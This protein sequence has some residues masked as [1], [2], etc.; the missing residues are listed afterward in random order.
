MKNLIYV[1]VATVLLTALSSCGG[2]ESNGPIPSVSL[3]MESD[4][5]WKQEVISVIDVREAENIG[6]AKGLEEGEALIDVLLDAAL[7]EKAVPTY[8]PFFGAEYPLTVEELHEKAGTRLDTTWV[9][10]PEPP[11]L[12]EPVASEEVFDRST[13]VKYY[14]K[15][16]WYYSDDENIAA[17]EIIGIIAVIE[18]FDFNNNFKGNKPL[19]SV[20]MD[21]V[22]DILW[23]ANVV[24]LEV[25]GNEVSYLDAFKNGNYSASIK[26]GHPKTNNKVALFTIDLPQEEERIS[27]DIVWTQDVWSEMDLIE[28]QNVGF[29]YPE[30]DDLFRKSLIKVIV[31]GVKE[32]ESI[33]IYENGVLGELMSRDEFNEI[34][35]SQIDTIILE[36]DM[37]KG[38]AK[39]MI[40][41]EPWDYSMVE[42]FRIKEKWYFN[43]DKEVVE[44]R[45][46]AFCPLEAAYDAD[47]EFMGYRPLF[48]VCMN[49][50]REVFSNSYIYEVEDIS[51]PRTY[52]YI[53]MNRLF[54]SEI[55]DGAKYKKPVVKIERDQV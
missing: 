32:N 30:S 35:G 36:K 12:L 1:V 5:K 55:L 52:Q 21:E 39:G 54:D 31:D 8:H 43:S 6:F 34:T 11:Y 19:F 29:A 18:V 48:W 46:V 40:V 37:V 53:F 17:K 51:V 47:E 50:L 23:N 4:Y 33:E 25:D 10:S 41:E 28:G 2:K 14:V 26:Q 22:K 13:V 15:E 20:Q 16:N 7:G 49:D 38:E 27:E 3:I 45:I 24:D 44:K 42:K 9:P